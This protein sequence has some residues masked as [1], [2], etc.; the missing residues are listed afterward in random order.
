MFSKKNKQGDAYT[1][2]ISDNI[3]YVKAAMVDQA[4]ALH[5][6]YQHTLR[7]A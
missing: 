4:T 6:F 3:P 5:K 2:N 1:K 7:N